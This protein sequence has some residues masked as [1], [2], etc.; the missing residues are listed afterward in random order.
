MTFKHSLLRFYL[1]EINLLRIVFIIFRGFT[2]PSSK[3]PST[4][5]Q[6][7]S[8]KRFFWEPAPPL[9][10]SVAPSQPLLPSSTSWLKIAQGISSLQCNDVFFN[11]ALSFQGAAAIMLH[12]NL[13]FLDTVLA[14]SKNT[15]FED[16]KR[17]A[18]KVLTY[19]PDYP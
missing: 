10:L 16:V 14:A 17:F 1:Q 8:L 7:P 11:K 12:K 4:P 19:A 15:T 13:S 3:K 5:A 6:H 2:L 9:P 18:S